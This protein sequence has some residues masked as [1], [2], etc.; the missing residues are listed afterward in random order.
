[1]GDRSSGLLGLSPILSLH[2]L[3]TAS[4]S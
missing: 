1:L 4:Q 2:M 3:A